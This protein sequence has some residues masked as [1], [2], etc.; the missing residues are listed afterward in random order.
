M[1][2]GS[3]KQEKENLPVRNSHTLGIKTNTSISQKSPTKDDKHESVTMLKSPPISHTSQNK[4]TS[5]QNSSDR[6][7]EK[8]CMQGCDRV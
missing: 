8:Y 4:I 1:R 7:S 5:T 2:L 6:E 3:M